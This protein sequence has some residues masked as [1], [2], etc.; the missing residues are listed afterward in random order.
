[1]HSLLNLWMDFY[2][3]SI[4]TSLGQF[5][6]LIYSFLFTLPHFYGHHLT[7]NVGGWKGDKFI[8]C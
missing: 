1:M 2:Q 5:E 7:K 3:T 4:D 8:L 6:E